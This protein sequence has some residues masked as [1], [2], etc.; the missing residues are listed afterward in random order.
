[1]RPQLHDNL[2]VN[3]A[4]PGGESNVRASMSGL[5]LNGS[6]DVNDRQA[7][8]RSQ[9]AIAVLVSVILAACG[10]A[11]A[12]SQS[13]VPLFLLA[14]SSAVA[15]A[16]AVASLNWQLRHGEGKT[17]SCELSR[18]EQDKKIEILE[19]LRWQAQD[20]AGSSSGPARCANRHYSEAR[21]KRQ[22]YIC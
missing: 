8:R 19:D 20:D 14:C 18:T 1:M 5:G 22:D 9:V 3:T 10:L 11:A 13:S 21:Y 7:R 15:I 16:A 4:L 17:G 2:A 6:V 12:G